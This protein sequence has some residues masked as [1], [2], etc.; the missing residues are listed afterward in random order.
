[1]EENKKENE[2]KTNKGMAEH[3]EALEMALSVTNAALSSLL[4]ICIKNSKML[5]LSVIDIKSLSI[6]KVT[7]E[8]SAN[9]LQDIAG[10]SKKYESEKEPQDDESWISLEKV[11]NALGINL[12]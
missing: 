10:Y 1:M 12:K 9:D 6:G 11:L 3:I 2:N 5:D 7:L 8:N 4:A